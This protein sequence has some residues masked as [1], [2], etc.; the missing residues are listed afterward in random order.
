ML[1]TKE[2]RRETEKKNK[3][4]VQKC[5]QGTTTTNFL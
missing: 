3:E 2:K 1:K 4:K 5:V